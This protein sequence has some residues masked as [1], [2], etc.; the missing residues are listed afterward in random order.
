ME[1]PNP[2][3]QQQMG[4][5]HCHFLGMRSLPSL[6]L[7]RGSL[8]KLL[9]R[10]W[11][12][13]I[14]QIWEVVCVVVF[15]YRCLNS[16]KD[17]WS[18]GSVLCFTLNLTDDYYTFCERSL[19]KDSVMWQQTGVEW[20]FAVEMVRILLYVQDFGK[21]QVLRLQNIF[22]L[23]SGSQRGFDSLV[24][25]YSWNISFVFRSSVLNHFIF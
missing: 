12:V 2:G 10:S 16:A 18:L 25:M 24:F 6:G 22:L 14:F 19:L 3:E 13:R 11:P 8:P 7:P 9:A 17:F 21:Y 1:K 23:F 5:P 20:E 4:F 15:Y